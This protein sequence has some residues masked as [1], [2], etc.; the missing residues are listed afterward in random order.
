MPQT[1]IEAAALPFAH[2]ADG[3]RVRVRLTPRARDSRVVGLAQDADGRAELRVHVTEAPEDGRANRALVRLLAQSWRLPKSAIRIVGGTTDRR[4]TV[5]VDGDGASLLTRLSRW[6][7][8][9]APV[10]GA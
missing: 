8:Q 5:L 3:V 7:T 1:S 9:L 6:A 4:K 10:D 2:V